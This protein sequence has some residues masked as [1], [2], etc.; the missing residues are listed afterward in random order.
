M[1]LNPFWL[2]WCYSLQISN[3]DGE[4]H[5]G[6]RGEW[7]ERCSGKG[8]GAQVFVKTKSK[9]FHHPSQT[10]STQCMVTSSEGE[11]IWTQSIIG[12]IFQALVCKRCRPIDS[13]VLVA[14]T[15]IDLFKPY[16]LIIGG[17][18]FMAAW[19]TLLFI[20]N[21]FILKHGRSRPFCLRYK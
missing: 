13:G 2:S 21:V 7:R 3:G 14:F 4:G 19:A 6:A 17:F 11:Q 8:V 9:T 5:V 1:G 12:V 15:V 16:F 18:T 20:H 10:G